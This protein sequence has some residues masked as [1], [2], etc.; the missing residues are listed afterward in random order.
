MLCNVYKFDVDDMD[1][2]TIGIWD[3][4]YVKKFN[5]NIERSINVG[6]LES[7]PN[8]ERFVL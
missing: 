7:L 6:L 2:H 8:L 3:Y 4:T 1:S 5:A